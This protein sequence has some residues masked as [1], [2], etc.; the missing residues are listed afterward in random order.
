MVQALMLIAALVCA[1]F[2]PPAPACPSAPGCYADV[3]TGGPLSH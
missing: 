2:V 3:T 1:A